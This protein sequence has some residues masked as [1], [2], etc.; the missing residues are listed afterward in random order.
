MSRY[1]ELVS[2]YLKT[3]DE[4]E[5]DGRICRILLMTL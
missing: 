1:D 4:Y 2:I 5:T 3:K